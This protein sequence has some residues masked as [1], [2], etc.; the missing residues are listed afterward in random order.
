MSG[1]RHDERRK[2]CPHARRARRT[3]MAAAVG[4]ALAGAGT[5]AA[6]DNP[7]AVE[8]LPGGYMVAG[9]GG[10]GRCAG[11]RGGGAKTKGMGEG[12]CAAMRG[13][14]KA[15]ARENAR[16][17]KEGTCAGMTG[18]KGDGTT[19][20]KGATEGACAGMKRGQGS[21]GRPDDPPPAGA[22]K[23]R[24]EGRCGEGKCG[25]MQ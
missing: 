1:N 19:T 17:G 16:A 7:F 9:K 21:D 12:Q 13:E 25:G 4:A 11:M 22:M 8:E 24:K 6:G 20:A 14:G 23:G 5:Q 15:R 2:A 3:A 18:M 10:E